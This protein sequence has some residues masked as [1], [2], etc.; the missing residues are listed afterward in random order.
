MKGPGNFPLWVTLFI[1]SL[2]TVLSGEIPLRTVRNANAPTFL[3]LGRDMTDHD[4]C[5]LLLLDAL[6]RS[7]S[8]SVGFE[9]PSFSVGFAALASSNAVMRDDFLSPL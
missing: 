3:R 7:P 6:R 5:E 2:S 8:F 9:Y 4:I 1:V